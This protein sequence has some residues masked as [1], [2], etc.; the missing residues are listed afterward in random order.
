MTKTLN[1]LSTANV[2]SLGSAGPQENI[3]PL[4]KQGMYVAVRQL[5][6]HLTC[7]HEQS[8]PSLVTVE[9][10]SYSIGC[11]NVLK[12]RYTSLTCLDQKKYIINIMPLFALLIKYMGN[13]LTWVNLEYGQWII[14]FL[15][16]GNAAR[17]TCGSIQ[18]EQMVSS[19]LFGLRHY[20]I[21]QRHLSWC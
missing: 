2:I 16:L 15:D 5:Y 13:L 9:T 1:P 20:G 3:G 7:W 4:T 19:S 8:T 6:Y 11:L 18:C 14:C 10:M 17:T 12:W 21:E